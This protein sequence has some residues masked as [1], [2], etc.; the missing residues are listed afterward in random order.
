MDGLLNVHVRAPSNVL[1]TAQGQLF[2]EVDTLLSLFKGS[3]KELIDLRRQVDAG[4]HNLKEE[5]AVQDSKHR[6]MLAQMI[7]IN[8]DVNCLIMLFSSLELHV[9]L[10][11]RQAEC[12]KAKYKIW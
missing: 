1:K 8:Y 7:L 6:K 9:E 2:P 11:A 3:C 4:L 5:V 10:G 12:P